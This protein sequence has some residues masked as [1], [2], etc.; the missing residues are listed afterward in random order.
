MPVDMLDEFSA[1][2]FLPESLCQ[3]PLED[4]GAN[5]R[6]P[7]LVNGRDDVLKFAEI[8]LPDASTAIVDPSP[9]RVIVE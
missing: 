1:N 6:W 2:R 7:T 8:F 9:F 3:S 5:G 4:L